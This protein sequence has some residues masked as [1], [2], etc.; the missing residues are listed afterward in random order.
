[1]MITF[2]QVAFDTIDHNALLRKLNIHAAVFFDLI[3]SRDW[4]MQNLDYI[5]VFQFI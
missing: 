3:F 5:T 1:M 4:Q 2:I